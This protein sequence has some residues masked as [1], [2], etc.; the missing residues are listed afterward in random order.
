MSAVRRIARPLLATTFVH[1][2]LDAFRHPAPRAEKAAPIVEKIAPQLGLPNDPELLVRAN[3]AAMAGAGALLGLGKLPR[4]AALVLAVTVVPTTLAEHRF[5]EI[6][7]PDQR[8]Q[9][10]LHFEKNLSLLGGVLLAAVDTD[11][12]PGLSWRARRTARDTRRSAVL[13]SK[14]AKHAARTAR[15]EARLAAHNV[16]NALPFG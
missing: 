14:E 15:R 8:K 9:Q 4:L 2:G 3:G 16:E 10:Q 7:D 5:W 12:K 13:A 6:D 1:G 11:G